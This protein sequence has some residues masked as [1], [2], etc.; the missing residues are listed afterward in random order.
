M[1]DP[2]AQL[3]CLKVVNIDNTDDAPDADEDA[4]PQLKYSLLGMSMAVIGAAS[5][6]AL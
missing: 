4:G 5:F 3:T 6:I 2:A 1:D